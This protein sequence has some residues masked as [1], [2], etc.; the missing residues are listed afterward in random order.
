MLKNLVI[1]KMRERGLS[2]RAV[3]RECNVAHTTINRVLEGKPVDLTTLEAIAEW[4]GVN[5]STVLGTTEGDLATQI[6]LLIQMEPELARV[7]GEA[8]DGVL[9]GD[10]S[11]K[12]IEDIVAYAT[13]RLQPRGAKTDGK[14]SKGNR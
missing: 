10:Y 11:R 2:A 13:F 4:L 6:S 14:T 3:A 5:L 8:M 1:E 12:D 7:F 9:K